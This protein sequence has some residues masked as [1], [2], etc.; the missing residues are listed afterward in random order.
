[1][2]RTIQIIAGIVV[3]GV[4]GLAIIAVREFKRAEYWRT[5]PM[6]K[7]RHKKGETTPEPEMPG[8]TEKSEEERLTELQDH[9]KV[10]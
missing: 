4:I 1:M 10:S 3:L 2:N 8:Q 9:E 6:R 7:A 5:E